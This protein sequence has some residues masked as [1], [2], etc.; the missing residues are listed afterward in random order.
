MSKQIIDKKLEQDTIYLSFPYGNYNQKVL[1]ICDQM[2]YKM[3]VSV[4]RGGNPFFADPLFLKRDQVLK[5]DMETF[6]TVLK[7]FHEFSLR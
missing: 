2:G 6:I 1:R 5:R 4:K 3:A 7:T